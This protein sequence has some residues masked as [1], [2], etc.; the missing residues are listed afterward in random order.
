MP[1]AG[2]ETFLGEV[3]RIVE[4]AIIKMLVV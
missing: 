4:L 1:L 2:Q 3:S